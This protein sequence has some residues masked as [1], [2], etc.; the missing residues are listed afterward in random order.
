MVEWRGR[1]GLNPKMNFN[2]TSP[3]L[4]W[5]GDIRLISG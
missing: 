5:N 3:V 4:K 2:G 1:T